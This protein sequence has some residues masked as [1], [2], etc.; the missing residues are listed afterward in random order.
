MRFVG[1]LTI[2]LVILL[3]RTEKCGAQ[4][5]EVQD[6]ALNFVKSKIDSLKPDEFILF[7]YLDRR[8]NLNLFNRKTRKRYLSNWFSEDS[9]ATLLYQFR[10]LV[11]NS[12]HKIDLRYA[13]HPIDS[14]SLLALGCEEE[15]DQGVFINRL[16]KHKE[17]G[18]YFLT[19]ALL[20]LQWSLELGCLAE[21]TQQIQQLKSSLQEANLEFARISS[22]PQDETFEAVCMLH[23][24]GFDSQRIAH[25]KKVVTEMQL[26]DGGWA[27]SERST[28]TDL[29]TTAFALWILL[30]ENTSKSASYPNWV[31]D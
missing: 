2:F 16:K 1:C 27:S 30:E 10:S 15:F 11:M 31:F 29:H 12:E 6:G 17:K 7:D 18:G 24:S 3:S 14:V 23:Y 19:H 25:F 9:S 28:T 5:L 8:F 26:E 13:S 4:D 22:A 20:A 21:S